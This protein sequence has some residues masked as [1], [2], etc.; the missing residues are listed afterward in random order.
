MRPSDSWERY[1]GQRVEQYTGHATGGF[2]AIHADDRD[3]LRLAWRRAVDTGVR[4]D[5][6]YRLRR[7]D[8][9][10][11]HV[12]VTAVPIV[13]D[14]GNVREWV[15]ASTD[16]ED[17]IRAREDLARQSDLTLT[18]TENATSAL[19]LMDEHGRPTYMNSAATQMFGFALE[20]ISGSPLHNAIHHCRPDGSPYP[21]D[22]CPIDRALPE[23]RWLEPYDDLFVRRDGTFVRVRAA[24]SPI[25]RDGIPVGTVVEVQDVTAEHDLLAKER[26]ARERAELLEANARNMAAARDLDEVAA[27]MFVSLAALGITEAALQLQRGGLVRRLAA[28]ERDGALTDPVSFPLHASNDDVIGTLTVAAPASDGL[29]PELHQLLAGLTEQCGLALERSLLQSD[30]ARASE[31]AAFLAALSGALEQRVTVRERATLAVVLLRERL[32]VEASI[33]LDV[34]DTRARGG[35]VRIEPLPAARSARLLP[36]VARGRRVGS[37]VVASDV[38]SAADPA[39]FGDSF[40]SEIAAR[41]GL[42]LDNAQRYEQEREVSHA[43]QLGLLAGVPTEIEGALGSFSYRPGTEALEVGG[44][45]YDVFPLPDGT[46]GLVVG[47]VAGHGLDAAVA[48]GQLRGVVRAMAPDRAPGALLGE[49]DTFVATMTSAGMATVAFAALDPATGL[50]RYACAGHPPPLVVGADGTTRLL[51]DGRSEPLGVRRPG[52]R[53]G[54]EATLALGE[55]LVLYSD[56]LVERR[57]ESFDIGLD[58][59]EAAARAVLPFDA[60]YADRLA[61]R[62]LT[63]VATGQDDDACVLA[64]QLRQPVTVDRFH[65][66]LVASHAELSVLRRQL[67]SW[68]RSHDIDGEEYDAIVLATSEAAANAVEHGYGLDGKR[69]AGVEATYRPVRDGHGN[70]SI[71]V[72]DRG[73]WRVPRPSAERGRGLSIMRSCMDVV[74]TEH[75]RDGTTVRMRREVHRPL[76]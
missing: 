58:R 49:L 30:I 17:E 41:L 69:R 39:R 22:E 67:G 33:T 53:T 46:L 32:G 1:T 45:W 43:L 3:D 9:A 37:L 12:R 65:H 26:R 35:T 25:M 72:R 75:D 76:R 55:A 16:V 50:L 62:L 34:D 54:A 21:I 14:A 19:F 73:T 42:A 27:S 56:G 63:G 51:W 2:D 31:Q 66:E 18:I 11:R 7:A 48:M 40:F 36:I 57:H 47:D 60:G 52:G 28:P 38:G 74:T 20:E 61:D 71:A 44:D 15:G 23:R 29:G 68:L 10:F 6:S 13:D 59:L 24:A 4:L 8:G 5:A 64:L 70:V